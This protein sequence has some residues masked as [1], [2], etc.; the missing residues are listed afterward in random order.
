MPS[1]TNDPDRLNKI[2]IQ[3]TNPITL[4]KSLIMQQNIYKGILNNNI[5]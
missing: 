3:E 2:G 4:P 5:K 1:D